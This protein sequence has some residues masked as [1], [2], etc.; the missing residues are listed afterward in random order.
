MRALPKPSWR[1]NARHPRLRR[2]QHRKSWM[3]A[4]AFA[5]SKL[6]VGMTVSV[7]AGTM[8]MGRAAT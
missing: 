4:P 2:A 7:T 1:A 5:R 3:P 6:F 8:E